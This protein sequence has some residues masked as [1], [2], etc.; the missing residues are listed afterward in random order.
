MHHKTGYTGYDAIFDA[1]RAN[2]DGL[3]SSDLVRT[4]TGWT[5][6]TIMV[7]LGRMAKDGIIV[8]TRPRSRNSKCVLPPIAHRSNYER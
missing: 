8:I 6:G 5:Q 2:P 3:K 4:C 1:L 7:L